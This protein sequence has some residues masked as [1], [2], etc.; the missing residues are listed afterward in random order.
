MSMGSC[1]VR[2]RDA[3]VPTRYLLRRSLGTGHHLAQTPPGQEP[4]RC[5]GGLIPQARLKI[6]PDAARG[7]LFQ[8]HAEFALDVEAFLRK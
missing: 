6:S 1:P 4:G 8:H 3:P 2:I 5:L 7:F